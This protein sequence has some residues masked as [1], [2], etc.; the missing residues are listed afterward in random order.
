MLPSPPKSGTTHA[1]LWLS[2]CLT[3]LLFVA[4]NGRTPTDLLQV[5]VTATPPAANSEAVLETPPLF[6]E[7]I[8]GRLAVIDT[9]G[10]LVTMNALG[11]EINRLST[12]ATIFRFPAWSPVKNQIAV[13]GDNETVSGIFVFDDEVDREPIVVH[14]ENG[15]I[16]IYLYWLPDGES[17]SFIA[18]AVNELAFFITPADG[19]VASEPINRGQPFYWQWLSNG[20]QALIHTDDDTLA[21]MDRD[22]VESI[23]GLGNQG[24]FQAPA[25]S[26]NNRYMAYQELRQDGRFVVIKNMAEDE[27]VLSEAHQGLLTM[28]WSPVNSQLVYSSPQGDGVYF[29][30]LMLWDAAENKSQLLTTDEALAFFWSPD[31]R[32]IAY[33]TLKSIGPQ[34]K[35]GQGVAQQRNFFTLGLIDVETG[36]QRYI[37]A[38]EPSPVFSNQIL[39]YFDQYALS[40][41]LWSPDSQALA[42]PVIDEQ[43]EPKIMILP[44]DGQSPYLITDGFLA[45]WS[46]Q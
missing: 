11:E 28:S 14:N 15:N 33:L 19:S 42:M 40:H 45:F 31:G 17:V 39:P 20:K 34:A 25:L 2:L 35:V 44:I 23:T 36:G 32:Y 30:P 7:T 41:R 13:I 9:R 12:D 22:G 1:W 26:R 18:N 46:H 43:D 16:P 38:F 4:C 10:R 8:D 6:D 29:G 5:V 37:T 3:S 24:A 21:F 27:I